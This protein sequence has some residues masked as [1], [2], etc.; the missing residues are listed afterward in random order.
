MNYEIK[1]TP[2]RPPLDGEWESA[3]WQTAQTAKI[4]QFRPES[5]SH[6]P[7]T[8][9]RLLYNDEG[10]FGIF[11]VNDRYV[12][13]VATRFQ[14]CVCRDSCVEF[15]FKPKPN[16]GYFN[17]EFNCGGTVLCSYIVM[18]EG[19]YSRAG[20]DVRML[21]AVDETA[22][23]V[24]HSM[25]RTVE[26]ELAEPTVWTLQFHIP[27]ALLEKYTGRVDHAAG[28]EWRGNLYKCGD[29]TSHPHW[30]AWSPVSELNFHLP[31]CFGVM[32][33]V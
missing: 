7:R 10:I 21:D 13:S 28:T 8:C 14:D 25:P 18:P 23:E 4:D 3:L 27:F 17:F 9:A 2:T 11:Q 26:P 1:E 33:F 15:F 22:I 29:K 30:A 24:H 32:K 31:D 16:G 12:R 20:R 5:S 6:R 19:D